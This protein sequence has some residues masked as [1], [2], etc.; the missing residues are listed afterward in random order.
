MRPD[1]DRLAQLSL[2]AQEL[3]QSE[4]CGVVLRRAGTNRL[5]LRFMANESP[6]DCSFLISVAEI[7]DV[8]SNLPP[9]VEIFGFF[10]S[11]PISEAVPGEADLKNAFYRGRAMIYDVCGREARVWSLEDGNLEEERLLISEN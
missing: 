6:R 8:E 4:I 11:H 1:Y 9:T 2:A 10:R 5:T 3:D 7:D